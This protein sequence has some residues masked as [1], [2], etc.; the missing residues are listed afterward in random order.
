MGEVLVPESSM[1]DNSSFYA[2]FGRKAAKLSFLFPGLGQLYNRQYFKGALV[3]TILSFSIALL[4]LLLLRPP[5][6]PSSFVILLILPPVIWSV[7][8]YD[9]YQSAI[10]QRRRDAKRYN[11]QIITTIRGCDLSNTSFEEITMTKNVSRLGACLI[12]SRE[13]IRGSQV[14]L[15]FEGVEKVRARVVW[16]RETG[17]REEHL[18]G[19]ELLTPLKQ[20]E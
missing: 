18:V 14:S 3:I 8:V 15:E 13:L 20:F 19:M 10:D 12:L 17:N 9:A 11:V 2:H 1:S 6:Q 16:S 5:S 4:F 7:A